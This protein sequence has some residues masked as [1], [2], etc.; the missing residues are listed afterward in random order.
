[1]CPVPVPVYALTVP[2]T[3]ATVTRV[4]ADTLENIVFGLG[5]FVEDKNL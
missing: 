4:M 3:A 5:L 2:M 1:M